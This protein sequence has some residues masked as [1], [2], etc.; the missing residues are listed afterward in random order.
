MQCSFA[1]GEGELRAKE[2]L[3]ANYKTK[4]CINYSG[5]NFCLYGSRCQF[6]HDEI[7]KEKIEKRKVLEMFGDDKE[8]ISLVSNHKRL[9]NE[10]EEEGKFENFE[11]LDEN[12]EE[13]RS[14]RKGSC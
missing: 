9:K 13:S 10:V 1:H 2:Y 11:F 14:R 6:I 4:K 12:E 5:Y 8:M 7:K 3:P